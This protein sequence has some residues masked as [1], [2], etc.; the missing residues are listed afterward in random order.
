MDATLQELN[1]KID[2]LTTQVSYLTEQA[3]NS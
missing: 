3:T 2:L 1:Q